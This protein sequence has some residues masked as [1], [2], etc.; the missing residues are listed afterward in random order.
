MEKVIVIIKPSQLDVLQDILRAA[1]KNQKDSEGIQQ[2]SSTTFL[3]DIHKS[4]PFFSSLVHN[5]N[6]RTADLLVVS[7]EDTIYATQGIFEPLQN[8]D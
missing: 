6:I 2:I 4:L 5:V 8:Y 7:V 1:T 3:I